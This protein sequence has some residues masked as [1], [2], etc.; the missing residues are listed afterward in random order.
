MSSPKQTK[1]IS[2]QDYQVLVNDYNVTDDASLLGHRLDQLFE[3]VVV[4]FPNNIALT[5]DEVEL[6]FKRLNS[7]ANVLARSLAKRGIQYGDVVGLAV[8]RS[9]DLVVVMLAVL[10]LG[11]AFVPID[12]TFPAE[13]IN[14]MVED[15]GPKLILHSDGPS[16]GLVHW[17]H[18]CLSIAQARDDTIT[19]TTNLG[20]EIRAQDLAYVIYT[21]GSTGRPKGVEVSHGAA[22]NFLSSLRKYEP[23]CSEH[24]RLLAI[25]TISFDMSA[26]ELLLPLLSGATMIIANESA[27]KDP[28]ELL[29]LMQRHRVTILQATPATWTMLLETGWKGEPRLSKIICG[30]EPLSRHL[31]DRLLASADSVWNV[32]GPCETTYGSVGRV[33]EGDIVVGNPVANG[34]IYVLDDDMSPV[35]MGRE[36]EVYIGGGSVSN[37]YRNQVELTNSRFLTNPF[38]GG[39][40][41]RTGDLARFIGPGKLQVLGRVD[42]V[43]KIRGHRIEVGDIETVLVDHPVVSE[44]VVVSRD[45]RLV[46]YCVLSS[47][48]SAVPLD[49]SLRPWVA[50]RL[51]SYMMPTFFV[52]MDALPL[53]PNQKINR[54]AL[55]D[56]M[57]AAQRRILTQPVSEL[58]GQIQAIW[59]DI[60]GHARIGVED[61]FFHIGGDSV[62]LIRMQAALEK[63]LLRPVS[64][65]KLFEHYTIRA[66]AGYLGNVEQG[67]G[68][69][70]HLAGYGFSG[71][72]EKIA[73]ISV[74]CRLPGGVATPE[75]FWQLLQSG[76]DATVD[77][78]K[79]RW[80]AG[81]LYCNEYPYVDGASYCSRG[82]FLDSVYSHDASF[83][84]ISPREAQAMDPAQHIMLEL[85]WESFERANYTRDRLSGSST[86]VFVGISNNIAT[87]RTPPDLKGYS[88]T[89]SAGATLSGRLSYTFGLQGPCLTID[90]ACSSSLVATHLACNALRQ[91]ECNMAVAGGISLLLNPGIHAEFSKL[92]ALSADGRCRAFSD[93]ADGTGFSEGAAVMILKRLSDARRD[94]DEVHAV[95][96]GS[97]VMHGGR[98]SGLTAPSGPGQVTLIRSA[99]ARAAIEPSD[100]DYIEAHGTATKLGDPIEATALAEVFGHGRPSPLML[101]SAKSNVGHTQ[102]AAGLVGLLKVVLSMRK[103]SIPK[104]LHISKPTT[105]VDWKNANMKLVLENIPWP[106]N[107]KRLRRAG[108]SA[109]GIGGT[110]AHIIV[111]EPPEA[112]MEEINHTQSPTL[113]AAVP[114]VLS[115]NSKSALAAQATRLRV[116]IE[117]SMGGDDRLSDIAYSLAT[118]R[119][120]LRHRLVVTAENKVQM[121][122]KLENVSSSSRELFDDSEVGEVSLGMLFTG[123]G[124]QRLGIG[125]DLYA[126]YPVFREAL[127]EIATSFKE[128]ELPLFDVIWA[129]QGTA[130]A[131]LL[132]RANYAQPALFALEVS[133]W[134]LWQ[135]WGVK[136]NF[137]LGHSVGELAVAHIAGVLD[138]PDACRLVMVRGLLMEDLPR[139]GKTASVEAS[140]AEVAAAIKDLS[141]SGV[142]QAGKFE[143]A[144]CNTPSQTV[145]SGDTEAVKAAILHFAGLGRRVKVLDTSHAFHSYHMDA[146]MDKLRAVVQT[147]RF[148]PPNIPVISS[149]TG[150]LA[151]AGELEQPEYWVQQVRSPVRF[152]DAFQDLANRGANTFLELGPNPVLC[153]LG[154]ACLAEK[155]YPSNG[156]LWIPSLRS[157]MDG[158]SVIQKG[159]GE[160]HVRHVPVDWAVYFKPFHCRRVTL[161]TYA[162]Q[163]T[164]HHHSNETKWS[165][166]MPKHAGIDE[167]TRGMEDMMFKIKWRQVNTNEIPSRSSWGLICPVEDTA[168]TVKTYAVLSSTGIRLVP[169]TKLQEAEQLGGLLCLW[170]S[171]A[172]VVQTAHEFTSKAL[173]QLQETIQIRLTV[174]VTWVTRHAIGTGTDDRAVGIGAA[175]L[176]G[177]MRTARSEHPEL[178]LRTID[179]DENTDPVVFGRALMLDDETEIAIRKKTLL[180]PHMERAGQAASSAI[181]KPLVRTDGSVLITGGLGGLG[182]RVARRLAT[183]HGH[184]NLVLM[185]RR[186]MKSPGAGA[187]VAELAKLGATATIVSGDVADL[188]GLKSIMQLFTADRPLRGVV[189]AAGITDSGTILSLTPQKCAATFGTKVNGTW[190]L[191]HLTKDID[192]DLFMV[193]SS[194]SGVMGLPG[195][196]NYAAAHAFVDAFAYLRRAQ[197]LPATSVA[198][199]PWE[200]DGMA[201]TLIPTT[202]SHLSQLGLGFLVPEVGLNLFEQA[203]HHGRELTI[204]TVLDIERLKTYYGEQGGAPTLLRSILGDSKVKNPSS[205]AAS[206]HDMLAVSAPQRH[207]SMVLHAVR[208]T[209]AKALG[210]AGIADVDANRPLKELG[211]DSL[212]AVLIRNRL[213][214]STGLVLRPNIA[215]FHADAKSLSE[216]LLSQLRAN[217]RSNSLSESGFDSATPST[218]T[219]A[220]ASVNMAAIR[221]GLLDPT[222]Q[223]ENVAKHHTACSGSPK[224]IFV[225]GATGFVGS[226]VIHEFM[227]K[228]ITVYC[229]V[230]A[231]SLAEAQNRVTETLKQYGLWNSEYESLVHSVVGDLAQP[232]LGLCDSDF[233][234]LANNV[235]AILHSGALVDWM[236]PFD[237]YV[238]PNILGT[239]EILRLASRGRGKA[240]H[241]IS[242]ISTLPI[243]GGYGFSEHD[244][245]YGYG[246][247]KYLA[248]RMVTAA[249][250]RGAKTS[251]YRLPF[252]TASIASGHFR[253]DHGDFLNNLISGSLDL[254]A[255]PIVNADLSS[256]LPV[257]YLC[258]TIAAIV[259]GDQ[260]RVGED[261][262]F[263]SLQA[264]TFDEF[265]RVMSRVSG[266]E[267]LVSF[268]EWQSRAVRYAATH[269]KNSLA[270]ITTITDGYSDETAASLL[271]GGQIDSKH[272]LGLDF[273]S[274]ILVDE[275]YIR[276]YLDRI[277]ATDQRG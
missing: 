140:G 205:R 91:G 56:P 27:V 145:I 133:L 149:M 165:S 122:D 195:L 22:A 31:A 202:R 70:S 128:L 50:E 40:F 158:P 266:G 174:P 44:A 114:F 143:I 54:K 263:V 243:H 155:A 212:T 64:T 151:E 76:G 88:I 159:L 211:I 20:T 207:S 268:S 162:F 60:L 147:L 96:S 130:N 200:G 271:K 13:R 8:S 48:S 30:G 7:Y 186:G 192:L 241:Y 117:N 164:T 111:E 32:Y 9:I 86:G 113:P 177:L 191:H 181:E 173:A 267:G 26:L 208:E 251:S 235:D 14:Q 230:R 65:P 182:R 166:G 172:N 118:C 178:R 71:S 244:V 25:T 248:E 194:I 112:A 105:A 160:L 229:L 234:D 214:A 98:S 39:R 19:N 215:L 167:A 80:D 42:G 17:K 223:F 34:R 66:L 36:G 224:T 74:A 197:G 136:P 255:F 115:G 228:G 55:P 227:K 72:N 190:N 53:S 232:H 274:A 265:F 239:H 94:G 240:V 4:S 210:H 120:H 47:S 218:T 170:D 146:M 270:R 221:K 38:H 37:G 238:G 100:I 217:S 273:N 5:H 104:T 51:P 62:R 198:Y 225:T 156:A 259:T 199:G 131:S 125:K 226:F 252:V 237:D 119:T 68:F 1:K 126:V 6:S 43:V 203:V 49:D 108:A 258:G 63:Q 101:G 73:V 275:G 3:D 132:D 2:D 59:I 107:R 189:H 77:V 142:V 260:Q 95:L 276:R 87:K 134:K 35:P 272:A 135:S 103:S 93:D 78:P 157:N 262:D 193:F 201:M 110:I 188:D 277:H 169:V 204:A 15:A 46:A 58:E 253:L 57:Q 29:G 209:I 102:A 206:L 116:H 127:D 216:F 10:K 256:V 11:A 213:A 90:T 242:T 168:W 69:T 233:D 163:R 109:F 139:R 67:Q 124:S 16:K 33:G 106:R 185:S 246:T 79:D 52:Q 269:P 176:W 180:A 129:E 231:D 99:L 153:G 264:P 123:Q 150:R 21:S 254:G 184:R 45:D 18:L 12:S 89:G 171:G 92:G 138:L 220:A 247:S 179:V 257:D 183:S 245:E 28:R 97:A 148:N 187:L 121:L 85:C 250:F 61:N 41:F 24:D 144:A 222:F 84:G 161:P 261:Y 81:K 82:G 196:G 83:F 141:E 152:S 75:E 137:I 175:P 154:A 219:S 236:R 23:G 249:R